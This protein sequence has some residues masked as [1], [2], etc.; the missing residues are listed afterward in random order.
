MNE[1]LKISIE[2][3]YATFS[4]YPFRSTME[5]CPCCVSVGDKE[6]LHT[7][8]LRFLEESDISRYAFKALT[9]WGD[10]DDFKHY[11][12][13]IFELLSTTDFVV[14]TFVVLKK[15][16]YANWTMWP[17]DEQKTIQVFLLAWW[18]DIVE[19]RYF[20]KAAFIEIYKLVGSI[21][22]LLDRWKITFTN[23]TFENYI[24]F[25]YDHFHDLKNNRKPFKALDGD[26]AENLLQWLLE[27]K[28][29][30]EEGFFH[31]ERIDN[32]FAQKVSNALYVIEH[33]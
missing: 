21:G 30:V 15:L 19:N 28:K 25:L 23:R 12:P 18:K 20:D 14:D 6:K 4:R 26:S 10:I 32:S 24:D 27:G 8:E 29:M 31:Y 13:R 3:L 7:K 1:E 11:L 22:P 9:T 17:D 2:G 5:G 33:V 16:T